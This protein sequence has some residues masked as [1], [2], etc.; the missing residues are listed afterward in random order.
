[1]VEFK[2]GNLLEENIEALVNTV[3]CVG[4][5]GKGIALQF[6][7]AFPENFKQYKKA[8]DAKQVQ[9]GQM[10]TTSTGKLFPRYIINFP[11]KRHW[12]GKSKIED[13]ESGLKAL[14][15]DVKQLKIQSIAIPPLGCGNGGLNWEVVKPMI[16]NACAEFPDVQVV[17]F[18]PIGTLI[19]D[20]IKVGTKKPNMTLARALFIHL[21]E[22]YAIPGYR[23]TKLEIQKLAYFLQEAEQP[24]KLRYQKHHYGPYADNL[25]HVLQALDGHF[26]RGYGDRSQESQMYVLPEGRNAAHNYLEKHPEANERLER[27]SNL[28][29]GFETPYGMEMLAT[30][31]WVVTKEDPQAAE[32]SEKA[33]ALVQEWNERKRKLFKP[34]HLKKAWQRLKQQNWFVDLSATNQ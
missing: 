34:S 6:K 30:I 29:T 15:E 18:E 5:M 28:I 31:H 3:N 11:T 20:Q 25:N 23:L 12:K 9:P 7:Q 10:F 26:I 4:V 2:Q 27:V 8:C 19:A 32:D 21:L 33:I 22:L 16:V 13:I 1:M 14:I 17:I 24:L